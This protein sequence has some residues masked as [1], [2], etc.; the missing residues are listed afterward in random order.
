MK[1]EALTDPYDNQATTRR[2]LEGAD[3]TRLDA[4]VGRLQKLI[5]DGTVAAR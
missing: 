4:E 5:P 1:G 3:R 2:R